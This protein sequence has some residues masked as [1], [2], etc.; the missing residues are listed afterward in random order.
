MK[1]VVR[2]TPIVPGQMQPVVFVDGKIR[3]GFFSGSAAEGR[4]FPQWALKAF[5]GNKVHWMLGDMIG[6]RQRRS[7][8]GRV[9]S[10]DVELFLPG[11]YPRCKA[12]EKA[13]EV[14]R[15]YGF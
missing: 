5:G 14:Q 8:C 15:K 13:L 1:S 12:C 10:A 11:N 9:V 4:G 3:E 2:L 7:L 6:F